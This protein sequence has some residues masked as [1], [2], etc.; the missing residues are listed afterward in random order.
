MTDLFAADNWDEPLARQ[1]T[2]RPW[3][4]SACVWGPAQSQ[5]SKRGFIHPHL[6]RDGKPVVM[7]VDVN[8]KALKSW[9]QELVD[10][11]QRHK[12][13]KPL[14]CP[15]A[16]SIL[17]YVPR[18]M[19]HYRTGA[20]A[21][22]LKPTAPKL[23]AAGRDIDKIA[24]AILDAGQIAR[25]WVNDARCCELKIR[26]RYDDGIGERTWVFAWQATEPDQPQPEL[27]E[28]IDLGSD[29]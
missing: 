9:R 7:I 20:A 29:D 25:W 21:G 4:G 8:D 28:T 17:L 14:D 18:P 5:G 11:M 6:K 1:P 12:P 23:P 3:L 16:V 15:V 27:D 26:R 24:R 22:E 19:S 10:A 13:V 2:A